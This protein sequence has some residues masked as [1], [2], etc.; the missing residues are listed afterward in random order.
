MRF[1]GIVYYTHLIKEPPKILV[2]T[3]QAPVFCGLLPLGFS[4]QGLELGVLGHLFGP[5]FDHYVLLRTKVRGRIHQGSLHDIGFQAGSYGFLRGLG[6]Q[7]SEV[8]GQRHHAKQSRRPSGRAAPHE[9][10][11]PRCSGSCGSGPADHC[12]GGSGKVANSDSRQPFWICCFHGTGQYAD[13]RGFAE[14]TTT[15]LSSLCFS[16]TL[17]CCEKPAAALADICLRPQRHLGPLGCAV[18]TS[19]NR[20]PGRA[21]C[22]PHLKAEAALNRQDTHAAQCAVGCTRSCHLPDFGFSRM[23]M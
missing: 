8:G 16:P 4:A 13:A 9:E 2:V 1:C 3:I 6:M 12:S 11:P 15:W 19:R 7:V 23:H 18:G 14:R 10:P 17:A 21:C 5:S 22:T 20:G